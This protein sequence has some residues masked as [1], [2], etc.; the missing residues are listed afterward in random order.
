MSATVK[1]TPEEI[2]DS[3]AARVRSGS[4]GGI[5]RAPLALH[6]ALGQETGTPL[7]YGPDPGPLPSEAEAVYQAVHEE[8]REWEAQ[9]IERAK[10]RL[11]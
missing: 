5:T 1:K 10:S 9:L 4:I 11:K 6:Y 8:I 2:I 7:G 3:I